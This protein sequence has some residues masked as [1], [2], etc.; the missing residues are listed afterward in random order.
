MALNL[1][2]MQ[3]QPIWVRERERKGSNMLTSVPNGLLLAFN[4]GN[5]RIY[6]PLSK[7]SRYGSIAPFLRTCGR[8]AI[9]V[10]TVRTRIPTAINGYKNVRAFKK[11]LRTV[12]PSR[13]DG[14]RYIKLS[15]NEVLL[16]L[17]ICWNL[18]C[19]RSAPGPRTVRNT[20]YLY[21]G[22]SA[23]RPRAVR[24]SKKE[25]QNRTSRVLSKHQS[26]NYGQS[27]TWDQTVR[28][29]KTSQNTET[30]CFC[31]SSQVRPADSLPCWPGQSAIPQFSPHS[32]NRF[33]ISFSFTNQSVVSPHAN[34]P[35]IWA[36]RH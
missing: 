10:R 25:N 31:P 30:L 8:S 33:W 34:A 11:D 13:P 32:R 4:P 1:T 35:T 28:S 15:Q 27:A 5:T 12:C 22:R 36:M 14:P 29:T 3:S 16:T 24:S 6:S 23:L 18:Y 19:G 20:K 26:F 9:Q 7:T 2:R 21:Y 17:H